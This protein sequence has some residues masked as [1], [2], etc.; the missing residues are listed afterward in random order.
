MKFLQTDGKITNERKEGSIEIFFL[1][2]ILGENIEKNDD[3]EKHKKICDNLHKL[4]VEKNKRYGDSFKLQFEEFGIL[5]LI[6]RLSDKLNRLKTLYENDT[7]DTLDEKF[8]DTLYDLANYSI[9]G[10]MEIRNTK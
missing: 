2:E 7:L 4:F 10:L 5:S 9:M 3:N 6:I 1:E 8:E